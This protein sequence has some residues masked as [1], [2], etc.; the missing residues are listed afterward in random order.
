MATPSLMAAR[1]LAK[2]TMSVEPDT[3]EMPRD[4]AAS[5]APQA[6]PEARIAWDIPRISIS[7]SGLVASGILSLGPTPTP[8]T[9]RTRS[10]PPTTA[11]SMAWRMA[12]RFDSTSSRPPT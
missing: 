1:E 12:E 8:P 10:T 5:R 3:P 7:S 6:I 4:V 11:V 9:V 2:F